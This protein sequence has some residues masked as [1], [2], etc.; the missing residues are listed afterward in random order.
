MR[1]GEWEGDGAQS[2]GGAEDGDM[3]PS[4]DQTANGS[5]SPKTPSLLLLPAP[6]CPS[7]AGCDPH[8]LGFNSSP[9]MP[10]GLAERFLVHNRDREMRKCLFFLASV[11]SS[12]LQGRTTPAPSHPG[13]G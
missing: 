4:S 3:A 7:E 13:L 6:L 10:R 2:A 8:G 12:V 1:G 11:G 9:A 5:F